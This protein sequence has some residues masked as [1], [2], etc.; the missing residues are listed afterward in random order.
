MLIASAALLLRVDI[1]AGHG[2]GKSVQKRI[3]EAT[4]R[5]CPA[6]RQCAITTL[7]HSLISGHSW[8]NRWTFVSKTL[9]ADVW[10]FIWGSNVEFIER[11]A[12]AKLPWRGSMVNH[13]PDAFT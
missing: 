13:D 8:P 1:K 10:I 4:D 12:T 11:H 2:A 6:G 3:E 5:V 7:T 9:K